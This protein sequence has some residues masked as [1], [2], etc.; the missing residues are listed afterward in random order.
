MKQTVT[1]NQSA[2]NP[3]PK[4][5]E[6]QLI[7]SFQKELQL[8]S[9]VLVGSGDDC[10]VLF[11]PD[12]RS[13]VSTDLL[14][15]NRHFTLDWL[16]ADQIGAR[17]ALQNLADLAAMGAIPHSA[18]VGITRPNYFSD[19]D[20]VALASGFSKTAQAYGC[21]LVGGDL[22]SGDQLIVA[23]TVIG[24]LQGAKPLLRSGA[25][26]D[27]LV[28]FAGQIGWS[29]LGLEILRQGLSP[30]ALPLPLQ[31]L[32]QRAISAYQVPNPPLASGPAV[33]SWANS[34][35]DVSDGL[36]QDLEKIAKESQVNIML[37]PLALTGLTD[38]L[39]PL[40][41]FLGLDPLTVVL[42][43]GEDHGLVG[44]CPPKYQPQILAAG[45]T[46]IGQVT[47]REEN[48]ASG[49]GN[50]RLFLGEQPCPVSGWD[51]FT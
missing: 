40:A 13:V 34:L 2:Q 29:A 48:Q 19:A 1:A 21:A 3:E 33:N 51:H 17:A 31:G 23:V 43:A 24:D 50:S 8:H 4:R 25:K 20:L 38:L 11:H 27:D 42:S 36:T 45:F 18:V 12:Q 6:E 35:M 14:V 37:D 28:I 49:P 30:T 22:T 32:A 39:A 9:K 7:S 41:Q 26:V 44:T 10:A 5:S 46:P 16:S 15:E 47:K